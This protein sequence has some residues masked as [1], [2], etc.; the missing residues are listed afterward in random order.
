MHKGQDQVKIVEVYYELYC[1]V[2]TGYY[3]YI[4]EGLY[5]LETVGCEDISVTWL[6]YYSSDHFVILLHV[7]YSTFSCRACTGLALKSRSSLPAIICPKRLI[8]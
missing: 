8:I 5:K 3:M 4:K 2:L 6:F 7:V 1:Y